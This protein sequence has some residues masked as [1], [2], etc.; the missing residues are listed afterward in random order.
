MLENRIVATTSFL[1]DIVLEI[2]KRKEVQHMK[3]EAI[4]VFVAD[5]DKDFCMV[6]IAQLRSFENIE[7]VGVAHDGMEAYGQIEKLKP[8]VAIIDCVMPRLDGL[9]LLEKLKKDTTYCPICI[10]LSAMSMPNIVQGAQRLGVDYFLIKPYDADKMVD[11]IRKLARDDEEILEKDEKKLEIDVEVRVTE[12]LFEMGVLVNTKGY[13]YMRDAIILAIENPDLLEML[14]KGLYIDVATM[15]NTYAQ[16]VERAIRYSIESL[17][18]VAG[19]NKDKEN[20]TEE[21]KLRKAELRKKSIELVEKV[22]GYSFSTSKDR[23]SNHQFIAIIV[24]KIRV[25]IKSTA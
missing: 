25:E 6:T 10:M 13:W 18:G 2:E 5:D 9:A 11:L 17:W 24:D 12:I 21:V 19:R 20:D 23:P 16:R 4:R 22:L 7:I 14:T 1:R 8:D 15:N 3:N